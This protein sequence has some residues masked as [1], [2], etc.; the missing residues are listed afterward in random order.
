[1]NAFR[2]AHESSTAPNAALP[3]RGKRVL[4]LAAIGPVP[5]AGQQLLRLG[6][7]VTVLSPQS[8]RGIGLPL[9]PEYDYLNLGKRRERLNL[10]SESGRMDLLQQLSQFDILLEGFRPG[11]LEGLGL[12]PDVLHSHHSRLVIGRCGGWGSRSTRAH[13]AGHDIN[14]LA[15]SGALTAIGQTAPVPPL[16]LVGDFGGA[17]MHLVAG[18]LAGL[19]KSDSEGAGSV[20]ETSIYEGTI[21][22][23]N[24]IYGLLDHGSWQDCRQANVLDGGAPYYR[25]YQT[26]DRKWMAVGA[27][28]PLFF[29]RFIELL[30]AD[31]AV[32]RQND[33]SYWPEMQRK[34]AQRFLTRK[35]D[36]W[37][38][39]FVGSDAC[40]TPVLGLTESRVHQDT[41]AFFKGGVPEPAFTFKKSS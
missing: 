32:E 17:A 38:D 33:R 25:C 23:M 34:I 30:G 14:F 24:M 6:A 8:D 3:L 37:N 15:L 11:K 9:P 26:A 21:S 41:R 1:M 12:A 7:D 18:V 10:K 36:D 35:R 27:I 4:E 20:V 31:V 13:D 5:F 39:V 19:I 16:N 29:Q 2:K 28:E 40:C 22:L